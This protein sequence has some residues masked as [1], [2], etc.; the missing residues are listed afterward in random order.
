LAHPVV[1]LQLSAVQGFPSAQ[2]SGVPGLQVPAWQVS[3]PL[4]AL[5]SEQA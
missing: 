2:L 3:A 4:H 5:P 1:A